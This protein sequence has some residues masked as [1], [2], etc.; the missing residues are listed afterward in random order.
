VGARLDQVARLGKGLL[1][2][3]RARFLSINAMEL[4]LQRAATGAA[5][6]ADTNFTLAV[7]AGALAWLLGL[8]ALIVYVRRAVVNP[9]RRVIAACAQL[10]A[11]ERSMPVVAEGAPELRSLAHAFNDMAHQVAGRLAAE[12]DRRALTDELMLAE[13]RQ[14]LLIGS[15]PDTLVALYD[16]ELRCLLLDGPVLRESGLDREHFVGRAIAETLPAEQYA[17]LEPL[18]R[19]A[20]DGESGRA[21]YESILTGQMYELDAAPYRDATGQIAGA[22]AVG[23]DVTERN[24]TA[25]ALAQSEEFFRATVEHAPTGIA[26]GGLDGRWLNVNRALCEMLGYGESELLSMSF[27]DVTHPD[28]RADDDDQLRRLLDGETPEYRLRKRYRHS[29]GST[30]WAQVTVALLRDQ[31]G[32]PLHFIVHAQDVTSEHEAQ[33]ERDEARERFEAAFDR[34]PIGMAILSLDGRIERVN[35]ALCSIVERDATDLLAM[36]PFALI[37]P[38]DLRRVHRKITRLGTDTDTLTFEHRVLRAGGDV[39]WVQARVT[40]IRGNADEPLHA[41]AQMQDITEQRRY[42]E[43]LLEM[44]DRDPLTGL[45]NRRGLHSAMQSHLARCRRTGPVG[46][47]LMLDLDGF[48]AVNDTLGHAGGDGLLVACAEALRGRL[49]ETDTIARLG[50]DEFAVLLPDEA[51]EGAEIAAQALIDTVRAR[52]AELAVKVTVSIGLALFADRLLSPDAALAAADAAMYAAKQA[53][54]DRFGVH[55]P[56]AGRPA[57]ARP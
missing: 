28:D 39:A 12:A 42:E 3:I 22:F 52:T 11:G 43:Q 51:R 14:R 4:T 5:S 8:I 31:Q 54:K 44:A 17:V 21:E 23:R 25:R 37:E 30:V 2:S 35:E 46:A 10:A 57:G 27:S 36:S 41:L 16:R 13:E 50:G 7:G 24:E 15:L 49:R 34:S 33:R 47:L 40:L 55:E 19:R 20:L 53:G 9:T 56:V 18:I 1:D 45:L 6:V 29:D 26:I 48:K 38:A 32:E